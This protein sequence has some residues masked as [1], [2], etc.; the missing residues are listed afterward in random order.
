[1][2]DE[3]MVLYK[4]RAVNFVQ[5]MPAKPIKHGLIFLLYVA[6]RQAICWALLFT[7]AKRMANRKQFVDSIIRWMGLQQ[8]QGRVLYVDNYYSTIELAKYLYGQCQ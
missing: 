3:S 5:Y 2:L 4:G 8:N 1:M 6:L 7:L